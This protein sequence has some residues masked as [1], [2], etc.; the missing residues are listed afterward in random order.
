MVA[1]VDIQ[2]Q[3]PEE[4]NEQW[5]EAVASNY[6]LKILHIV[7]FCCICVF[8]DHYDFGKKLAKLDIKLK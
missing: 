4:L 5:N 3:K 1:V 2:I 8:R 6:S 7:S